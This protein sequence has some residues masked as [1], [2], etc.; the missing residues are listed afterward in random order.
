M[1]G[2]RTAVLARWMPLAFLVGLA[3]LVQVWGVGSDLPFAP[4]VDEPIF[5][6]AAV[7]V[8][9]GHLSPGWFGHPGSTVIYP[10]A[11]FVRLWYG[12]QDPA[13]FLHLSA[14]ALG[15]RLGADPGPFYLIGRLVSAA[16]AIGSVA[17]TWQLAHRLSDRVG[18]FIAALVLPATWLI[19]YYGQLVRTDSAGMFFVLLALLLAMRLIDRSRRRD[20]ILAG[21]AIGLAVS[22]RYFMVALVIPYLAA[23]L[24]VRRSTPAIPAAGRGALVDQ[25]LGLVAAFAAFIVTSPALL[26]NLRTAIDDLQF[27]A[28]ASA[29]GA[30]GLSA[31]G[32]FGWYVGQALPAAVGIGLLAL[33]VL[34]TALAARRRPRETLIL[35]SFVPTYLVA[36]SLSPL[37]WDRYVIPIIPI[38]S[39]FAATA[40]ITI[41]W[42]IAHL[43]SGPT[44]TGAPGSAPELGRGVRMV[45]TA[46]ATAAITLACLGLVPSAQVM[47]T[48]D[49]L[50]SLPST[51]VAASDWAN[52]TLAPGTQ[53]CA[54]MYT[55]YPTPSNLDQFRVFALADHSLDDYRSRGCRYLMSSSAMANRFTDAQRYPV[56]SA[57]YATLA[58]KA[59]LVETFEPGPDRPGPEIRVYA[60][61]AP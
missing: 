6:G 34:G 8:A 41:V 42:S 46:A 61:L 60:V 55:M 50:R 32:N 48:Q 30:D 20:W 5:I 21:A 28:R 19:V 12:L 35:A 3:T 17:L 53:V 40:V 10:I 7:Q 44:P 31:P 45:S 52:A 9:S 13:T 18:A 15:A 56:E 51:R 24:V 57:F 27:E 54:E 2:S 33:A 39:A 38:A 14:P 58:S 25:A 26:L 4:D 23:C 49:R 47:A 11:A 37:H 36:I 1:N 22:T 59:S 29:P 43:V 16:Y